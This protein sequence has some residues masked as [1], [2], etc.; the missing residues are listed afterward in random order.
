MKTYTFGKE[1]VPVAIA[2]DIIVGSVLEKNYK[3]MLA[4]INGEEI[5]ET[6]FLAGKN[7]WEG[8]GVAE[9]D[10]GYIIG[11]AVEGRAT[12]DGGNGWKAY[13]ARLDGSLDVLW[14]QK[15]ESRD[16][17]VNRSVVPIGGAIFIAGETGKPDNK[18]FFIGRF[19]MNGELL[20]LREFG[21]WEDDSLPLCSNPRMV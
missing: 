13:V 17:G 21:C 1:T 6:R 3:I 19:S 18:R 11:G 20:W 10:D 15:I 7:E 16:N 2:K 9:L 8:Q 4:R 12:S 5:V 14:K